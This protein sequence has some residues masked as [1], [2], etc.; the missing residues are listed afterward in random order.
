M[1]LILDVCFVFE[2]CL[3]LETLSCTA[4]L[5]LLYHQDMPMIQ[6]SH[7]LVNVRS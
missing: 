3:V 4:L 7:N 6:K 2:A 5:N 1:L